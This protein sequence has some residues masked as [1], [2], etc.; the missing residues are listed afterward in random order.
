MHPNALINPPVEFV[1]ATS[2]FLYQVG[3]AFEKSVSDRIL[4]SVVE[5][6]A[7]DWIE[8]PSKLLLTLIETF[9]WFGK[10]LTNEGLTPVYGEPGYEER[11]VAANAEN[12]ARLNRYCL[13]E[14]SL[15]Y[16]A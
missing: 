3:R 4:S 6:E 16:A 8:N 9:N 10:L 5:N 15:Q 1:Q 13:E 11:V 14:L 2:H 7:S 12:R